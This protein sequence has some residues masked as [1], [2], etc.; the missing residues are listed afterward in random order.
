MRWL[1]IR[2]VR[3]YQIFISPFLPPSCRFEPTCSQYAIEAIQTH[4]ALKGGWMALRRIGRCNPFCEGGFDPV[5]EAKSGSRVSTPRRCH[6]HPVNYGTPD[7]DKEPMP[8]SSVD[9]SPEDAD[10]CARPSKK[11]PGHN[12]TNPPN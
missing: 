12:V 7:A 10:H 9:H 6:D 11:N 2:L 8:V 1:L 5:P 3:F 4:G